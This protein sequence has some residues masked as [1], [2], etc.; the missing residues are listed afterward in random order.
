M[1]VKPEGARYK[2]ILRFESICYVASDVCLTAD[3]GVHGQGVRSVPKPNIMPTVTRGKDS[4]IQQAAC[5]DSTPLPTNARR[6]PG[7]NRR[8]LPKTCLAL[9]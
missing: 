1:V 9:A 7:N 5:V 6:G 3:I 2:A 4:I 8:I